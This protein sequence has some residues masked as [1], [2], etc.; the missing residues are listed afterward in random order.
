MPCRLKSLGKL[1]DKLK[2]FFLTFILPNLVFLSQLHSTAAAGDVQKRVCRVILGPAQAIYQTMLNPVGPWE[3][4]VASLML[5]LR[6]LLL[7]PGPCHKTPEQDNARRAPP[8][9]RYHLSA[10]PTTM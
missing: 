9:V 1:A 3:K 2:G 10:I 7:P 5:T 8:T 6:H 4:S